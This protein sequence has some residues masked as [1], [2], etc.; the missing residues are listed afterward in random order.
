VLLEAGRAKVDVVHRLHA[1]WKFTSGPYTIR[2]V[3]T[4][5]AVSW[6]PTS[7]T[8]EIDMFSGAVV[9]R[10][11][12]IESGIEVAGSQR[13][14]T[15]SAPKVEAAPALSASAGESSDM[16]LGSGDLSSAVAQSGGGKSSSPV[17][18]KAGEAAVG[19]VGI[20]PSRPL[21]VAPESWSAL[22]ATGQHQR[23]LDAAEGRGIDAVL[24][25]ATEADLSALADA[26]RYTGRTELARR[27]LLALRTR[28]PGT[29]RAEAAAFLLGRMMDDAGS[30]RAA[31]EWYERYLA[32]APQGKFGAEVLGRRMIALRRIGEVEACRSAAKDYLRRFPSGPYA[33]VASEIAE[34]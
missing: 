10:G 1:E 30:P 20:V 16:A 12:G 13:F 29:L 27:S 2:V 4:S 23:V 33:G 17:R 28:F 24:S 9:V 32:E 18:E 34:P 14:V 15:S 19:S 26:A 31:V 5:F 8:L 22:A 21:P 11:P 6:E 25:G 3:G 7:G